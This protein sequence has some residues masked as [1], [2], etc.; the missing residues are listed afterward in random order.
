MYYIKKIAPHAAEGG[1]LLQRSFV[2]GTQRR[3]LEIYTSSSDEGIS[4][5][6]MN[7]KI[8]RCIFK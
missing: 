4:R 3:H 1:A 2:K 5:Y 6:I 8:Q 7:A